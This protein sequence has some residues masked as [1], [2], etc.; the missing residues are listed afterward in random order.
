MLH[1]QPQSSSRMQKEHS[2]NIKLL[3]H[4]RMD[5]A[6]PSKSWP[7]INQSISEYKA[8]AELTPFFFYFK[9]NCSLEMIWTFIV[10][11]LSFFFSSNRQMSPTRRPLS[12]ANLAQPPTI[13]NH[14]LCFPCLPHALEHHSLPTSCRKMYSSISYT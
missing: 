6:S 10:S 8:K 7:C 3:C 13:M 12:R 4:L 9:V 14:H 2:P 5:S 1:S 11:F